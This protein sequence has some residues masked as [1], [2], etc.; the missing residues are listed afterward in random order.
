M[1][2][3]LFTAL[4]LTEFLDTET[5]YTPSILVGQCQVRECPSLLLC[6]GKC[7]VLHLPPAL[8]VIASDFSVLLRSN[9]VFTDG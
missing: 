9:Y 1:T 5:L 8:K 6:P 2:D 7:Q 4:D 3:T